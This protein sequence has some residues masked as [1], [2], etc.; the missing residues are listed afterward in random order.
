MSNCREVGGKNQIQQQ[1]EK[2]S[3]FSYF[4]FVTPIIKTDFQLAFNSRRQVRQKSHCIRPQRGKDF[5]RIS[6][7]AAFHRFLH[8]HVVPGFFWKKKH[9]TSQNKQ[10]TELCVLLL[11]LMLINLCELKGN[12]IS[13]TCSKK[14]LYPSSVSLEPVLMQA[15]CVKPIFSLVPCLNYCKY[16]FGG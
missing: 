9:Q 2:L 4:C 11:F 8:M 13:G 14:S 1:K 12:I 15:H 5:S 3:L 7:L 16:R 10:R 6:C